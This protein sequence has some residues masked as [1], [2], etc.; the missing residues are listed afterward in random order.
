MDVDAT[1]ESARSLV[2]ALLEDDR[3]RTVAPGKI[4]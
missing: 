2:R 4:A 3:P 1:I